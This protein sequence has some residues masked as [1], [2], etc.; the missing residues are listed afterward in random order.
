MG[1]QSR[2]DLQTPGFLTTRPDLGDVA[3]GRLTTI[4]NFY[5]IFS[6][7]LNPKQPEGLRLLDRA[8]QVHFMAGFLA[9]LDFPPAPK[10]DIY[11]ALDAAK[12]TAG[13]LRGESL[14]NGKA[15]CAACHPRPYYIDNTMHNPRAERFYKQEMANGMM[16]AHD[17][18]IKTFSLR[19][20][21][22]SPPYLHDGRCFTLEDTVEYFNLIQQLHLTAAEKQDLASFLRAL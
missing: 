15:R 19:G 16:M 21:K 11:G 14:F 13:E 1:E 12:A 6:G 7:L 22:N 10:L 20:M 4:D 8:S 18:P 17:G 3:K 5:E 2:E 9:L